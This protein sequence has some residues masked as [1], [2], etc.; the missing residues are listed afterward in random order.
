[1]SHD[2]ISCR[3]HIEPISSEDTEEPRN[4][5]HEG[6]SKLPEKRESCYVMS[7]HVMSC[8]VIYVHDR[9]CCHA[10]LITRIPPCTDYVTSLSTI[11]E[12]L[13]TCYLLQAQQIVAHID[14]DEVVEMAGMCI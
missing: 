1:M 4:W 6:T 10:M 14:V 7:C 12:Q 3:C 11:R 8:Y 5:A 2:V 13:H 9:M